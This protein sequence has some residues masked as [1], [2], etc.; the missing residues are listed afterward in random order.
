[1]VTNKWLSISTVFA[2]AF[3]ASPVGAALSDFSA[4]ER[5]EASSLALVAIMPSGVEA[6]FLMNSGE[7]FETLRQG[8][9]NHVVIY[10][11]LTGA[12]VRRFISQSAEEPV[13]GISVVAQDAAEQTPPAE[14][15]SDETSGDEGVFTPAAHTSENCASLL[16]TLGGRYC[17]QVNM[18]KERQ[19]D[20]TPIYHQM[21]LYSADEG[22]YRLY[23]WEQPYGSTGIWTALMTVKIPSDYLPVGSDSWHSAC[24]PH[25]VNG[26]GETAIVTRTMYERL[27]SDGTVSQYNSVDSDWHYTSVATEC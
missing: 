23:S 2:I 25:T 12:L 14:P 7:T 20:S 10:D 8:N 16:Q 21:S 13:W 18:E 4:A 22:N 27:N 5:S 17:A 6:E 11:A 3:A 9:E 1:M 19:S 15:T 26:G 24:T